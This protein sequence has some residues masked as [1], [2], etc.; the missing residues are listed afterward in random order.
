MVEAAD[1]GLRFEF[2]ET[3]EQARARN[4]R[5][6]LLEDV[7]VLRNGDVMQTEPLLLT[8][9]D[10]HVN[11]RRELPY[12]LGRHVSYEAAPWERA[13]L[14]PWLRADPE[15]PTYLY[16]LSAEVIAGAFYLFWTYWIGM[17]NMM[18]ANR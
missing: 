14:L 6:A 12:R 17:R 7:K 10:L 1:A 16:V 18:Y 2:N 3:L 8:V 5:D 15:R 13:A 9:D 11:R 4:I